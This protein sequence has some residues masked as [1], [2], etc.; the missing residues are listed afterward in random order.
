MNADT[1][2]PPGPWL[3]AAG[4]AAAL[5][6]LLAGCGGSS[7]GGTQD[8]TPT[9][10]PT[11]FTNTAAIDVGDPSLCDGY[12]GVSIRF[13]LDRNG[14]GD[15]AD[16]GEEHP[17]SPA[18][19]CNG[20]PGETG[21]PG[22]PGTP[23]DPGAPGADGLNALV[24]VSLVEPGEIC[25]A[26]GQRIQMGLDADRDG[27][28]DP[29]EVDPALTVILCN[30]SD[31]ADGLPGADG[32]PG[33]DGLNALVAVS[34]EPP[35]G[36][37]A[38]GGQRIEVGRDDNGNG[39][40]DAGEV[41]GAPVYVCNG[42]DG[43][44]GSDGAPG[45]DG[46][47]ALVAVTP[48]APGDPC[49]YGGQQVSVGLD[50]DRD[51]VLD[52]GEID[53]TYPV[54]AAGIGASDGTIP[55]PVLLTLEAPR[56]GR[57]Q[58]GGTSYYHFTVPAGAAAPYLIGV[59]GLDSDVSWTLYAQPDFT[60]PVAA[61]ANSTGYAP[62]TRCMT[63][64]LGGAEATPYY[65]AVTEQGNRP[66]RYTL[67][68]GRAD[69]LVAATEFGALHTIDPA[70]G[71]TTFRSGTG[72][73]RVTGLA[74]AGDTLTLYGA[75]GYESWCG[76]CVATIDPFTG[77]VRDPIQVSLGAPRSLASLAL[78]HSDGLMLA[79]DWDNN[80]LMRVF[81]AGRYAE[82][83]VNPGRPGG[84]QALRVP[85]TATAGLLREFVPG[86]NFGLQASLGGGWFYPPALGFDSAGDLYTVVFDGESTL[87]LG[88]DPATGGTTEL[89][90]LDPVGFGDAWPMVVRTLTLRP[91][92][93]ALLALVEST[94]DG[95]TT[96]L[97]LAVVDPL[98][99]TLTWQAALARADLH[100]AAVLSGATPPATPTDY[101]LL[102][103]NGQFL[104]DIKGQFGKEA[105]RVYYSSTPDIDPL[106][107]A[108]Y[109]EVFT[110]GSDFYEFPVNLAYLT[111]G[112]TDGTYYVLV[113]TVSGNEEAQPFAEVSVDYAGVY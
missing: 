33:A 89:G 90:Y 19:L 31:G 70:T 34:P 56:N 84:D 17:D 41:L 87:L 80:A 105:Y 62:E 52:A 53:A 12:G 102:D 57:V 83:V 86:R 101:V 103:G 13:G 5:V 78:R 72:L 22:D 28:L 49:A 6:L 99:R 2:R 26:G 43:L 66:A 107:P 27:A 61:C 82:W 81:P 112:F 69:V 55:A 94:P 51:G 75:M 97:N 37:C 1:T 32:A 63:P 10:S 11:T 113:T 25:P 23:G 44:P 54:C 59:A 21:F 38:A 100:G 40:L 106:E 110:Y 104:V 48:L 76:G 74:F 4:T 96:D 85:E 29:V 73:G 15:I 14:D 60:G 71:A 58:A 98:A 35:G 8:D 108:S 92:D 30:G 46:L 64:D 36:N 16:P 77:A 91:T 39:M 47:N 109:S 42:E 67:A 111:T 50:D 65:L 95:Y 3:T 45:A 20:A 93:G 79:F 18:V 88:V 24:A 9:I 7:G 68:V